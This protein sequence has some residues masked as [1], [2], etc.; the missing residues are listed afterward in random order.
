MKWYKFIIERS[1]AYKWY[2]FVPFFIAIAVGSVEMFTGHTPN[3]GGL[4]FVGMLIVWAIVWG[5]ASHLYRKHL[6]EQIRDLAHL[7]RLHETL[8]K[9]YQA[10]LY[11]EVQDRRAD[12]EKEIEYCKKQL[13]K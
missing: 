13:L 3:I 7:V 1:D 6:E 2:L 8:V 4:V 11:K 12:V 10:P 9:L 5:I